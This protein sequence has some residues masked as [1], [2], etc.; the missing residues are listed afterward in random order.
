MGIISPFHNIFLS[1]QYPFPELSLSINICPLSLYFN[2]LLQSTLPYEHQIYFF[3][4]VFFSLFLL[5]SMQLRN[6]TAEPYY[7]TATETEFKIDNID[8]DGT[9]LDTDKKFFC[10]ASPY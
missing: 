6:P 5:F 2:D 3:L 1:Q 9:E 8:I 4:N 10:I 7:F